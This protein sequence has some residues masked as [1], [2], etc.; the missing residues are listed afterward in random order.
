MVSNIT[1]TCGVEGMLLSGVLMLN[2][3]GCGREE[4]L[5]QGSQ[6]GHAR[7]IAAPEAR[8]K[9]DQL[10][11]PDLRALLLEPRPPVGSQRR[12]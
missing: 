4:T 5:Y 2:C 1:C 3:L 9:F 7:I 6:R 11:G 10:S 8:A 12:G